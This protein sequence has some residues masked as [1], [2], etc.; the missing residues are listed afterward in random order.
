MVT[1]DSE[2]SFRTKMR[3]VRFTPSELYIVEEQAKKAGMTLAGYL[4]HCAI[5]AA[6]RSQRSASDVARCQKGLAAII[7]KD[8]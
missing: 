4:R 6:R 1:H 5:A 2:L 3:S 7:S 8:L